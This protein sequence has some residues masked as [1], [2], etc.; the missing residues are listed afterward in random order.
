MLEELLVKPPCTWKIQVAPAA[1]WPNPKKELK[2]QCSGLS[3]HR[4]NLHSTVTYSWR[5]CVRI[6]LF[7]NKAVV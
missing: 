4:G 1:E 3:R 2:T 7:L 6:L 5:F